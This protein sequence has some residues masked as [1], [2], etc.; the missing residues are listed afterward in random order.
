MPYKTLEE[1]RKHYEKNK[2]KINAKRRE[3]DKK[4]EVR[5]RLSIQHKKWRHRKGEDFAIKQRKWKKKHD[6]KK[7]KLVFEHYGKKC[8]CCGETEMTFLTIDHIEGGG[9]KHRKKIGR[10]INDW[11][12]KNNFPEGFQTLCFNCNWGKH[13][14]GGICPHKQ[15]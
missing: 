13:I 5:K 10:K 1:R 7:K 8:I 12:V 9:E 15:K 2:N 3:H 14:N 11:L 4:P 6:L